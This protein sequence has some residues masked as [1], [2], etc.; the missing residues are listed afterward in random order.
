MAAVR[1]VT[2]LVEEL[3]V[4]WSASCNNCSFECHQIWQT[5]AATFF[6]AQKC[7]D[8]LTICWRGTTR[9]LLAVEPESSFDTT[10]DWRAAVFRPCAVL[11]V[12]TV[13]CTVTDDS[14]D[15]V[16]RLHVKVT[17]RIFNEF[18]RVMSGSGCAIFFLFYAIIE[19]RPP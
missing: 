17:P 6:T 14:S 16:D 13:L 12:R 7:V 18:S 8:T 4:C 2:E 19:D 1:V 9:Q 3:L 5:E 15:V 11:G 10:T